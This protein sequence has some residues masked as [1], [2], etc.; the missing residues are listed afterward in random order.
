MEPGG[1]RLWLSV[2]ETLLPSS[3][4]YYR[5]GHTVCLQTHP[6]SSRSPDFCPLNVTCIMSRCSSL[7]VRVC[8]CSVQKCHLCWC[9]KTDLGAVSSHPSEWQTWC[10]VS[11]GFLWG[12]AI[13]INLQNCSCKCYL[14]SF[15]SSKLWNIISGLIETLGRDTFIFVFHDIL[16]QGIHS[17]WIVNHF[18]SQGLVN[19][20]HYMP[21]LSYLFI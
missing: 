9:L 6:P 12:D 1:R 14:M 2:G 5:Q 13:L 4:V 21:A 3:A 11:D 7:A 17:E 19:C 20:S 18:P 10:L 8:C 15:Y 16:L